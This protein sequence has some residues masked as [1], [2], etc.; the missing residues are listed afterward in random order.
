MLS[1]TLEN[2][3][4]FALRRAAAGEIASTMR[5]MVTSSSLSSASVLPSN[6]YVPIFTSLLVQIS[7]PKGSRL[8]RILA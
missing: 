3:A 6:R 8:V 2:S 7:T 5:V 4:S 1:S